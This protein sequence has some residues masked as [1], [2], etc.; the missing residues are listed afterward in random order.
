VMGGPTIM[1]IIICRWAGEAPR[2]RLHRA[3]LWAIGAGVFFAMFQLVFT[4]LHHP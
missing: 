3:A 2:E 1:S 4:R